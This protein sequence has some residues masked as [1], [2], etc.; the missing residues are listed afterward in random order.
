MS[1]SL[2]IIGLVAGVTLPAAPLLFFTPSPLAAAAVRHALV[3]MN[4]PI[5]DARANGPTMKQS[6]QQPQTNQPAERPVTRSNNGTS[7]AAAPVAS[8]DP[9]EDW[10][11]LPAAVLASRCGALNNQL[12]KAAD[13]DTVLALVQ[14]NEAILNSVNV[15]TALHRI[16]SYLKTARAE[17]DRVLRDERFLLLIDAAIERAP[18]SNPRSVSDTIWSCAT[19]RYLPPRMLTPLLSQVSHH[20]DKTAFEAQ[21]LSLI[22]W[23]LAVLE[24]KPVRLLERIEALTVKLLHTFNP[25]NCANIMWGFAKLNYPPVALLGP[26]TAKMSDPGFLKRF[27]P[28]EVSDAAFAFAVLGSP[29]AHT[30]LMGAFATQV[31]G[32]LDRYSSRQLVMLLWSH[33]R[34]GVRPA[35]LASWVGEIRMAHERYP[36]LAQDEKNLR[37]ALGRFEEDATWLDPLQKESEPEPEPTEIEKIRNKIAADKAAKDGTWL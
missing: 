3:R 23:S 29:E 25:Q 21:H 34:V 6:A 27:K 37:A 11:G 15:A 17:R 26:M 28:V 32:Q 16:A 2:S 20:L 19:L 36:L 12:S 24:C 18:K 22:T 1:I 35:Q 10:G 4:Q 7:P 31:E 8:R 14:D 5:S 30:P 9:V 13:A 33:A